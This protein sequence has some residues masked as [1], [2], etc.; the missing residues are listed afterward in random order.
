MHDSNMIYGVLIGLA[1]SVV[2]IIIFF[3]FFY[4][5]LRVKD[6]RFE[7]DARH[8]LGGI[9]PD[10][11][12]TARDA[13][14]SEQ[15]NIRQAIHHDL[16]Q[17]NDSFRDLTAS[18]KQ[19]IDKRQH[20]IRA[21]EEDRNRKYGEIS[22]ALTDYKLLTHELRD[23]T[24]QLNKILS[25]NQ[26][27]GNW[28]E[29]QAVKIFEAAGMLEGT[30]YVKQSTIKGEQG[31]RPDFTVFLP[32]KLQLH[33]DAKFPLQSLQLAMQTD[34]TA[35]RE[36]I[37]VQFGRDIRDRMRETCKYIV[38]DHNGVDY[39]ILFVPSESVFEII[40]RQF[41]QI[42]DMAF[43]EK[44]ILVSPHSLFAV[45]RIIHESYMNFHYEQNIREILTYLHGMLANFERF[46]IEFHDVGRA[47]ETASTRYNQIADTRYK[48]I[49]RATE[50]MKEVTKADIPPLPVI[51]DTNQTSLE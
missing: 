31:L 24:E 27:R 19:E 32:N 25:N 14:Q 39:V 5:F 45:V 10:L 40:N 42:V 34:D 49:V 48:Q 36:K 9:I 18:L 28:G 43:S 17:Q 12:K 30:H 47:I 22:Q 51:E 38:P 15:I 35:Q 13:L 11:V 20:E 29:L 1:T 41:P 8:A 50:R 4:R 2:I 3:A 37:L 46:K 6:E 21:L 44:V 16:K 26:L 7:K 23:S 33:I